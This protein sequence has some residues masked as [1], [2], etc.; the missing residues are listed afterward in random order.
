MGLFRLFY[1]WGNHLGYALRNAFL[2][3]LILNEGPNWEADAGFMDWLSLTELSDRSANFDQLIG[4]TPAIDRF[5]STLAWTVPASKAMMVDPQPLITQSEHGFVSMMRVPVANGIRLATPL[6]IG[7]GLAAPFAGEN[8]TALVRQLG[9][10]WAE[11]TQDIDGLLVSGIPAT[12]VWIRPLM[13]RFVDTERIGLGE[14]CVRRMA[15]LTGGLDGFMSRRSSKFR[16]NLRRAERA[17]SSDGLVYEFHSQDEGGHLFQRILDIER[18][19]WKGRAGEGFDQPPSDEFYQR[20][21]LRL[22]RA[23]RLRVVMITRDGED[24]AFVLGGVFQS[25]YRGLQMSY[26]EGH[27]HLSLG[28]LGQLEMIRRLIDEGIDTYDLGTEMPYK[29]SWAETSFTT[30]MFVIMRH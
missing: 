20:M 23:G 4:Q 10:M 18:D 24:L 22:E 1:P 27:R 30:Q 2:F 14:T 12:G 16:A 11:R 9:V 21:A 13:K 3:S 7:W 19:S 15:S 25:L 26:R 6:E 29:L 28:N 8:P 5:C 17:G